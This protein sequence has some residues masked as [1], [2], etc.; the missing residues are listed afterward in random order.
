MDSVT[1]SLKK[2][3]LNNENKE[4]KSKRKSV[5]HSKSSPID[6]DKIGKPSSDEDNDVDVNENKIDSNI[7]GESPDD[8]IA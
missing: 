7:I 3:K 8:D 1:K 4:N 6:I 5:K 2:L